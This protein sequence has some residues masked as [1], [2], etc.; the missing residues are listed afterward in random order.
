[1]PVMEQK[2]KKIFKRHV[3]VDMH[4]GLMS[5][6]AVTPA[7]VHDGKALKHVCPTQTTLNHS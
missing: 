5:K 2:V 3:G 1:M 4:Q 6:I 7:N